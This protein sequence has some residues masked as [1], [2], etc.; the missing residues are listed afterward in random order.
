L[1]VQDDTF[2]W[3]IA[4]LLAVVFVAIGAY[5]AV[6]AFYR[7]VTNPRVICVHGNG[8]IDFEM[9]LFRKTVIQATRIESVER[10]QG[11]IRVKHSGGAINVDLTKSDHFLDEEAIVRRLASLNP[12]MRVSIGIGHD[13]EGNRTLAA[14][15]RCL[16]FCGRWW[17]YGYMAAIV[18]AVLIVVYLILLS[19]WLAYEGAASLECLG[20]LVLVALLQLVALRYA[21]VRSWQTKKPQ[22]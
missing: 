22:E 12:A 17:S 11:A 7:T 21:W 20:M 15:A 14:V 9:P 13:G 10:E 2:Q 18:S 16:D 8:T 1:E 6:G 5:L 19:P 4:V 3:F